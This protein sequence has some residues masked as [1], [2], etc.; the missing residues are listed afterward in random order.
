MFT[1]VKKVLAQDAGGM[2]EEKAFFGHCTCSVEVR[3]ER[4]LPIISHMVENHV[5]MMHALRRF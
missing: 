1:K 5:R 2:A 3:T 4:H